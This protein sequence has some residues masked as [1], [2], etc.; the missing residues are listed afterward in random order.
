M[1]NSLDSLNAGELLAVAQTALVQMNTDPAGYGTTTAELTAIGS[2]VAALQSSNA[3]LVAKDAAKKAATHTRNA[4]MHTV[5]T[6]IRKLRDQAKAKG[7]PESMMA[8]TGIPIG[9]EPGI[10]AT[11]PLVT[12]DTSA[13]LQH[14]LSWTDAGAANS[15]KR[16]KNAMGVE[17]WHKIDG[18]PPI[19]V[20]ECTF[21]AMDTASPYLIHYTGDEGGKPVHYMLRWQLKDGTRG[22]FGQT[23]TATV[24]A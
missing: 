3:D 23:V 14:T 4:D 24:A 9:G 2:D 18:P 13:R 10:E 17:I 21:V 20:S 16:P 8:A 19:G 6:D 12:V 11:V 5:I 7:V 22:G 1:A 15:K